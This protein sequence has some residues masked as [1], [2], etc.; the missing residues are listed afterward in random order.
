MIT[1]IKIREPMWGRKAVG[2][3]PDRL[4]NDEICIDITYKQNGKRLFPK[5][6]ISRAEALACPIETFKT[7]F[8]VM[9]SVKVIPLS[10]LK[11]EIE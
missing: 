2:I 9:M 11:E 4:T 7:K 1:T 5:Y 10:I 6:Y 8:G 3:R